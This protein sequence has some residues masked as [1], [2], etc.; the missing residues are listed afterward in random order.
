MLRTLLYLLIAL[1]AGY[2]IYELYL[3][4]EP[5]APELPETPVAVTTRTLSRGSISAG[6]L[7]ELEMRDPKLV[8][9][10]LRNQALNIT[11]EIASLR[12]TGI[13]KNIA[14]L[15]LG[16]PVSR[17]VQ[18]RIDL[19]KFERV[20]DIGR[21]GGR[22]E[23]VGHELLFFKEGNRTPKVLFRRGQSVNMRSRFV[24]VGAAELL[25]DVE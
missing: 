15:V 11:G 3:K 13:D 4:E 7:A 24:R 16:T 5:P 10:Q 9:N 23:V 20:A 2:G 21:P 22:Y 6:E 1:G 19:K 25:F 14:E 8:R 12:V 17:K 18:L